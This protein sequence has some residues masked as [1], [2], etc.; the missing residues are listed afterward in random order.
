MQV[1]GSLEPRV[2]M[3]SKRTL[4]SRVVGNASRAP[5]TADWTGAPRVCRSAL[6]ALVASTPGAARAAG[7]SD[8]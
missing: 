7:N 4:A 8:G 3:E 2:K 5:K 1:R 6:W